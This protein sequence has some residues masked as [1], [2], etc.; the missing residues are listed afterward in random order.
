MKD[1]HSNQLSWLI[2]TEKKVKCNL[3]TTLT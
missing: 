2:Q 1:L 3:K